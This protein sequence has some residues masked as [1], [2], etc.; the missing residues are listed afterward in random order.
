MSIAFNI[1]IP[2]L[3]VGTE[4]TVKKPFVNDKGIADLADR[5]IG[6]LAVKCNSPKQKIMNLSGGN[7]QKISIG[8]WIASGARILIFDEPTKGID[9]L[10][11]A[12]VYEVI[13]ELAKQGY[14]ILV[15]SSYNP[16]LQG[17]CD[18]IT[19][20]SKGRI[21]GSYGRTATEEELMLAQQ[22]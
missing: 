14:A 20:M 22:S 4:E 12:K 10:A 11:K 3:V 17:V 9:V 18:K 1:S 19:V 5:I 13:R 8:K 2:S 6:R 16:E 15:I 7:Q 21:T